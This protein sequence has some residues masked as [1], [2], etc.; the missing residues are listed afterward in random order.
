MLIDV[1]ELIH[2]SGRIVARDQVTVDDPAQGEMVVPC[3]VDVDYRKTGV[4]YHLHATVVTDWETR[5]ARCLDLVHQSVTGEFDLV[6]KHE[7][8]GGE[9]SDEMILLGP[10]E[11]EVVLDPL[12]HEA[13]LLAVPMVTLCREDCAGLCPVCGVN[14][15]QETCACGESTDSRW[16]ALKK[17]T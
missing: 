1:R 12:V 2:T 13:V 9:S 17:L 7:E 15:N 5:C 10:H 8:H 3:R 4:A 11:H 16:D 6:V 14:R